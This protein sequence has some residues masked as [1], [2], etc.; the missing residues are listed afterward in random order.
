MLEQTIRVIA[1]LD[2]ARDFL[3]AQQG[4]NGQPQQRARHA[5]GD[6]EA[7]LRI[8]DQTALGRGVKRDIVERR[9][10]AALAERDEGRVPPP[11]MCWSV[12]ADSPTSKTCGTR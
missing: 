2:D 5:I 10:H 6:G 11:P 3:V 7:L 4:V 1:G 8:G 9:H 12:R